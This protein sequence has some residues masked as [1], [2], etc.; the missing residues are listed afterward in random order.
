VMQL[1]DAPVYPLTDR[2]KSLFKLLLLSIGAAL[3]LFIVL[4]FV[5]IPPTRVR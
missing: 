4:T 2:K 3:V 5:E 1:L